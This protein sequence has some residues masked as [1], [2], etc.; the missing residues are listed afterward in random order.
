[1]TSKISF[2]KMVRSDMKR[3]IWVMALL[4]L[5]FF[6]VL[7]LGCMLKV[8]NYQRM[9]ADGGIKAADLFEMTARYVS[10][11]NYLVAAGI[12]VSA[13]LAAFTGFSYLQSKNKL[14]LFHSIP[15]KRETMF[16]MQYVSGLFIFLIPYGVNILLMLIVCI[17]RTVCT[18]AVMNSFIVGIFIQLFYFLLFYHVVI[19]AILMTGRILV[20]VFGTIVF[21]GYAP[22]LQAVVCGYYQ[23]Y[24]DT[25]YM[26]GNSLFHKILGYL[27]PATMYINHMTVFYEKEQNSIS[28][29]L[30][31]W[32]ML[33]AVI[34]IAAILLV[35]ALW[36]YKKRPSE[37]ALHSM[38]FP[39]SKPV[40]KV[41]LLTVLS[42]AC[43]LFFAGMA[44]EAVDF[45]A[46]FGIVF[47]AVILHCIVEVIYSYEF[48]KVLSQKITFFIS[49][50]VVL[51]F[52]AVFR[53]DIFGYDT[54]IP[55]ENKV[56]A[57]AVSVSG[58]DDYINYSVQTDEEQL[59]SYSMDEYRFK[60]GKME[61]IKAAYALVRQ[62]VENEKVQGYKDS[63]GENWT[64]VSVKFYLK[65]GGVKYRSYHMRDEDL[66]SI[67]PSLYN[68]PGFKGGEYP[69][70]NMNIQNPEIKQVELSDAY[71]ANEIMSITKE[72]AQ[73]LLA[74]YQDELREASDEDLK[75]EAVIGVLDFYKD[76]YEELATACSV[77]ESFEETRSLLSE[78]GYDMQGKPEV[79]EVD[80]ITIYNYTEDYSMDTA[81]YSSIAMVN[82]DG[83]VTFTETNDIQE[84]LDNSII[85]RN[86]SL[87][88]EMGYNISM[89]MERTDESGNKMMSY[90][91]FKRGMV[92][93]CVTEAF[94]RVAEEVEKLAGKG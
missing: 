66:E 25:F 84:I 32:F 17:T 72:D 6:I 57:M 74:V 35:V 55:Q 14:D 50:G 36:L 68:T 16:G 79:S 60:Y 23:T 11:D 85:N 18:A 15:V 92:P 42:A 4:F 48:K 41:L 93:D 44:M 73:K 39:K 82:E 52:A 19:I 59:Y 64:L 67:I 3:R 33:A 37:A 31:N 47:G 49:L 54:R 20:S 87:Y 81:D 21:F 30:E 26:S 43:G 5:G 38:V 34:G 80:Q 61:D 83:S 78:L 91:S 75:P 90:Y 7:P 40:I 89:V 29:L 62:G 46:V 76:S 28:V 10:A 88:E 86:S 27:S 45:W 69:L 94:D 51:L 70:L 56:E 53:F 24:F 77:Y 58:L 65:G 22:V 2:F 71:H 8:G 13:V 12:V 9:L 63:K 1:M